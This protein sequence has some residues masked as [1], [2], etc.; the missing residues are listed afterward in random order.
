MRK[1]TK[2]CSKC[3]EQYHE[4]ENFCLQD[5][6]PLAAIPNVYDADLPTLI[7]N[8][9][10]NTKPI[11]AQSLGLQVVVQSE[12]GEMQSFKENEW[13]GTVGLSRGLEGFS[14]RIVP[15]LT[16]LAVCYKGHFQETGDTDFI[17]EGEFLRSPKQ[18]RCLEGFIVH[19]IGEAAKRYQI[20]YSAHIQAWMDTRE[21]KGG[22][23]CGTTGRKL[24]VE[25]IKVRLA[26]K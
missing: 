5:G 16:D 6:T 20:F 18:G 22:E 11:S 13:A 10:Y 19:L 24:R 25:A 26:H 21:Y 9:E 12:A 2:Q 17:R 23:F 15:S 14:L 7:L 3:H 1:R 4:S 8:P